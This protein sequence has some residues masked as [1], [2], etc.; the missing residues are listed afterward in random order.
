VVQNRKINNKH[1]FVNDRDITWLSFNNRVLQEA[2]DDTNSLYDRLRFL[3]IFS[4]NLDE[5]FRV[6]VA[7]INRLVAL[8]SKKIKMATSNHH[9]QLLEQINAEVAAQSKI[10][11]NTFADIVKE[12]GKR[13][14]FIK[15]NAQLSK[16]QKIFVQQYFEQEVRNQIVPLMI[17]SIGSL[18][19]LKDKNLYLACILGND[20]SPLMQTYSLIE[21]P[22]DELGRFLIL[23][24][25]TG[26][27]NIILLEDV[28][29]ECLPLLFAQ[30]GF[31]QYSS[32]IIKVTRD[33]ELDID[34]DIS[35]DMIAKLEKGLKNRKKGKATRF[36][37]EKNIDQKLLNYLTNLLLL[38]KKD[39]L[40]AGGKYHNFK[41]FMNFPLSLFALK[42]KKERQK[43]FVHPLLLQPQRILGVLE[44]RDVLLHFPYHS[45]DSII[46]LLRECSIDPYVASIKITC[47][48][49]A[50]NSKILNALI[51]AVRNGKKVTVILELR[52]RF[53]EEANLRWKKR[54]EEEGVT[55]IA[56]KPHLKVHAK[57]C[58]ITKL[59]FGKTKLYGFV[60]TGN[61][62]ENTSK[63]YGDHC[64]LTANKSTL[65]GV[66]NMFMYLE[67]TQTTHLQKANPIVVSPLHT[68]NFFIDKIKN[69]IRNFKKGK[70]AEIIIKLNSLSDEKCI[71]AIVEAANEGV[72]VSVII[73]GIFCL[74]VKQIHKKNNFTAISLVDSYLEHARVFMFANAGKPLVYLSS[75]DWMARNLDHRVE[76]SV[77]IHEPILQNELINILRMQLAENVKA[78]ILNNYTP[79]EYVEKRMDEKPN[80]SQINISTFLNE[81]QY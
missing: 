46:D 52:A 34:N 35:T 57:I 72:T 45:F 51:N 9:V 69:E 70:P 71:A 41:D 19:L 17:E 7:T 79:N 23:P 62:N 15:T 3:G 43:P 77:C 81:Q 61:L 53:D 73:R 36:I 18:P 12:L 64:L 38:T 33:A 10:F 68:R 54:L 8:Q 24:S 42:D 20:K 30:F 39:N 60:S 47:Y 40:I 29:R 55:V 4:N 49:L 67:G 80:R 66:K 22:S 32:S 14:I 74:D 5:F 2:I 25:P 48:R 63:V 58:L 44:D 65:A 13:K 37:Y 76:A 59:E 21:I 11:E 75:A 27:K 6:R 1:T 50:R 78:R 31:N 26:Q 56:G 16:D 28:I